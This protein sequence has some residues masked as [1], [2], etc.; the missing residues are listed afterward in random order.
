MSFPWCLVGRNGLTSLGQ[1]VPGCCMLAGGGVGRDRREVRLAVSGFCM[2]AGGWADVPRTGGRSGRWSLGAV[3]WR[4]AG[5]TPLRQAGGRAGGP[6]VLYVGGRLSWRPS[7]RREVEQAVPGCCMLVGGWAHA[8][9]TGGRSGRRSLGAL[10]WQEAG[11]TS[12]RQAGGP[13]DVGGRLG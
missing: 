12:L 11:L 6:W 9:Q 7:H 1:A 5:L 13:W 3:C 8:P 4:K 2:L 10:Y